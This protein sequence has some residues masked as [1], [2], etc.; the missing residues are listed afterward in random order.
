M[1]STMAMNF[2][3]KLSA[4]ASAVGGGSTQSRARA[5]VGSWRTGLA[6]HPRQLQR[7]NTS[8]RPQLCRGCAGISED[9][10][11]DALVAS[12]TERVEAKVEEGRIS[13][14]QAGERL[15][16]IDERIT[17]RVNSEPGEREGRRGNVGADAAETDQVD[18]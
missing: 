14:E 7:P 15:A 3:Q 17:E 13:Q 10:L 4:P 9:E 6:H 8:N 18:A 1:V 16:E 2:L 11:V 12:A 5:L